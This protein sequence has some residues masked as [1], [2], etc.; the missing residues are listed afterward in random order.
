MNEVKCFGANDFS[1]ISHQLELQNGRVTKIALICLVV[2]SVLTG[3][4][5]YTGPPVQE[6]G[7]GSTP[8]DSGASPLEA[9]RSHPPDY[10]MIAYEAM[11]GCGDAEK[12]CEIEQEIHVDSGS[13][14]VRAY[15][16]NRYPEEELR[17]PE[18]AGVVILEEPNGN[19]LFQSQFPQGYGLLSL[20]TDATNNIFA[21]FAVTNHSSILW[22]LRA[23][24][25]RVRTF[26][27]VDGDFAVEVVGDQD[28]SGVR[29]LYAFREGWPANVQ[30][31]TTSRDV[32]KWDGSQ[33]AYAGCQIVEAA[34]HGKYTVLEE[35]GTNSEVC[36]EPRGE[37]S[38]NLDGSRSGSQPLPETVDAENSW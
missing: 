22:V 25:N 10:E 27:S 20:E 3:C 7:N 19:V 4:D 8:P 18:E 35:I 12:D 2:A 29:P 28:S 13:R 1:W 37:Y 5:G 34:N 9:E 23:E 17:L 6:P 38:A 33:Y 16:I 32:F 15:G 21:T 11:Q 30:N 31:L 24:E 36:S 14:K 26:G